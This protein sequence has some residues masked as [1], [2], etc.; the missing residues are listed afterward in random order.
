MPSLVDWLLHDHPREAPALWD[1]GRWRS[2][3]E[4]ATAARAI[5]A[6]VRDR[7]R[8]AGGVGRPIVPIVGE[9]CFHQVAA[10]LGVLAAGA[11]PAP[12]PPTREEGLAAVLR[13]T[14]ARLLFCDPAALERVARHGVAALPWDAASAGEL[15]GPTDVDDA[16]LA[17][18]L[19]TSGSTGL[20]RGVMLS[21]RSLRWNAEAILDFLPLT[22][23]DRAL[24][25]LPF[26]YC[27]GLSVLHTHLVAGASVVLNPDGLADPTLDLM[28]AV[29][30]TGVPGVPSFFQSLVAREALARRSLP[31]L[32]YFMVSGGKLHEPV[33]RALRAA[34]PRADVILRYGITEVTAAASYLP[35]AELDRRP[36]SIGRGLRGAPLAVERGDG[37]AVTPGADEVGEIVVRGEHVALGYFR[38]PEG[39][40]RC[41]APGVY[42][43][44]DLARID[45]DGYVSIVGREREFVKTGGHRVSPQEIEDVIALFPEVQEVGVFGIAHAGRGEA[46]VAAVVTR[47]GC[48]LTLTELRRQC[49]AQL[50]AFKIP[51]ELHVVPALPRTAAGKVDRRA[52]PS[53]CRAKQSA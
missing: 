2:R 1:R 25:T 37:V 38:D 53:A 9:S 5:G 28:A 12:L 47:P 29:A 30:A 16:A 35:A 4:L 24:T 20:P 11:V 14:E 23:A 22:S 26:Y 52:L 8:P 34:A 51:V 44:G 36:G 41:F 50:P 27:Y 15:H 31:S 43:T 40:R 33:I 49:T 18:L 42:R 3:G 32:R 39:T 6:L 13:E 45:A 46:L 48:A 21:G 7:A 19:Y 10:Y 17:V